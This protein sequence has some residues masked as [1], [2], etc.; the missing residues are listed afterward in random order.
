MK[1]AMYAASRF[2]EVPPGPG[3]PV[4]RGS[5]ILA[6]RGYGVTTT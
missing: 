5:V 2:F 3:T 6:A 1:N 4:E